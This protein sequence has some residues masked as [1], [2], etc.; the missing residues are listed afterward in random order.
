MM[1][2][3]RRSD[4]KS[5]SVLLGW[6]L[7]VLYRDAAQTREMTDQELTKHMMDDYKREKQE[8]ATKE[9]AK[10]SE[11]LVRKF[12]NA[13]KDHQE[14]NTGI[15]ETEE[16]QE[17]LQRAIRMSLECQEDLSRM[18]EAGQLELAMKMSLE[19]ENAGNEL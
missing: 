1:E 12:E 5:S 10:L 7:G 13:R 15:Q 18:T 14:Q 2:I 11:S 9:A 19:M 16:E 17:E 4:E 8:R 3:L 6:I